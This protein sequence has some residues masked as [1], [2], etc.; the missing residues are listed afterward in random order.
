MPGA[1]RLLRALVLAVCILPVPT[2]TG[3]PA[4]ASPP[5]TQLMRCRGGGK[6][7]GGPAEE[8][9]TGRSLEDLTEDLAE[10]GESRSG[11]WLLGRN[12]Y[13]E[14]SWCTSF[15]AH[16]LDICEFP[17][18]AFIRLEMHYP[19]ATLLHP[20]PTGRIPI[21]GEMD[22]ASFASMGSVP[23]RLFVRSTPLHSPC[24]VDVVHS[25]CL[26]GKRVADFGWEEARR[27][28]PSWRQPM[29]KF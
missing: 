7:T 2:M 3:L 24:A 5:W 14:S 17:T 10:E 21:P 9:H 19:A 20:G 28:P 11:D 4:R 29:G 25:S 15:L 16:F 8:G 26:H 1:G 12:M 6:A 27:V 13:S 23:N 18:A 22:D